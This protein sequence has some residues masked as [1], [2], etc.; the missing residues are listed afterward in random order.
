MRLEPGQRIGD[1]YTL[2]ERIGSG[3]MADVWSAD[4]SMLGRQVALK[5]LH[6]RFAQDLQFV[7]RF[8]REA[9]AAAGLQHPNVVGVYDRGEYDGRH[10]IAMEYVQGASLKDLIGRGLSVAEGVEIV[11]QILAGARFAHERGIVHRD[12]KPHNVLVD[13]DGRARV[14]D[15]GIARAGAS[16]IT[17]T[18]SVLGTAQYLSPEQAQGLEVKETSDLYSIGVILYEALTGQV[19]FQAETAVAIALKQ[20]S[21]PP[22]RPSELNPRVPPALDAVV[23]KALAKDPENRFQSANEFL[24]ALDEAENDP[25]GGAIGA[26]AAYAAAATVPLANGDEDDSGRR[27]KLIA[28][29]IVAA[30]IAAVVVFALTRSE[31]VNV[32][33]VIGETQEDATRILEQ[34][35]FDVLPS[36]FESCDE[37]QTVAEQDPRAGSTVDEGSTVEISVSLGLRVAVPDVRGKPLA[38]ATRIIS[39]AELRSDDRRTFSESVAAG[40]V[41]RTE[42]PVG[43]EVMCDSVVRVYASKGPDLAPVPGRAG[44]DGVV[45]R[46]RAARCGIHPERRDGELGRARGDRDRPGSRPGRRRPQGHAG[47]HHRV[48]RGGVGDRAGRRGPTRGHRPVRAPGPRAVGRGRDPRDQRAE[49]GRPRARPGSVGRDPRPAGRPGDDLRRRVRRG[50]AAARGGAAHPG[51][52]AAPAGAAP[53]KVAVLSGGRS[54]EH[55]VSLRSGASVAEGLEAAGHEVVRILIERDGR[56]SLDGDEVELR[57]AAG[58]A[59]VDVAFPVLHGPFGEDGTVQGLLECLDVPYAGP[60]VLAAAVAMDKLVCKRLLAFH[61]LPQVGFCQ[62]G[63]PGWREQAAALGTPLWVKPSRLGSSVGI[64]KVASAERELDDAVELAR[65]HDPRVIIEAH[66]EGREVECSVIGNAEPETS[67]PGEIV[68]RGAEWYDYE[69]KYSEGGMELAVPA[70]ISDD[71]IATV[72]ELAAE[73]YRAIDCR[74]LARC[75]FF[76]LDSG[77]VLVNEINTIPGFTETSVFGKLWEAS[78]LSYPD[79]CDRLVQLAVERHREERSHA[80]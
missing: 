43:E 46:G 49:R 22:R 64:S 45:G 78:G 51:A 23:L 57:A 42:P 40:R 79:L 37:P 27:R 59:G 28:L 21:E 20:V 26:T 69:A 52:H 14:A 29:G 68:T 3:G 25:S 1:R 76:V 9:Q 41:V 44:P 62:A 7:E 58:L 30:L 36:T 33:T 50:G 16:E 34:A 71:A 67:L 19:P 56:W 32:P 10:W 65:S 12:L 8:R 74:G 11:R 4:D 72:R 31:Q 17:Q 54:S 2:I 47:D 5:F 18:G 55:E 80:F 53:M 6:E 48:D 60:S 73:V 39:E 38:D 61:G 35:G 77:D 13:A 75:D 66:A 15:F 24:R 70:P 63:E